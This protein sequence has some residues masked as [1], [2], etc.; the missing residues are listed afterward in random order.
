MSI[1]KISDATETTETQWV[2]DAVKKI[3]RVEFFIPDKREIRDTDSFEDDLLW[4]SLD[5]VEL[6]ME[7]EES[8]NIE[9]P[10]EEA[11]L[12]KTVGEFIKLMEQL[13]V[14][15]RDVGSL[16]FICKNCDSKLEVDN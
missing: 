14:R 3:I 10:D 8:F 2:A 12:A 9:I 15:Q 6:V 16:R 11:E 4:D 13:I 1:L 7:T 5:L